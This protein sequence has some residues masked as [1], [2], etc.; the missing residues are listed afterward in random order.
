[1]ALRFIRIIFYSLLV[2]LF[3]LLPY[4]GWGQISSLPVP[5]NKYGH[6][7]EKIDIKTAPH[8]LSRT[9]SANKSFRTGKLIYHGG[10][11]LKSNSKKFGG[12]SGLSIS[13]DGRQ[14]LAVSD[15]SHWLKLSLDYNAQGQLSGAHKGAIL[16][17]LG[18][19]NISRFSQGD[20]ESVEQTGS[21]LLVSFEGHPRIEH[22][23]IQPDGIILHQGRLSDFN[24]LKKLRNNKSLESVARINSSTVITLAEQN[25]DHKKSDTPGYIIQNNQQTPFFVK[26][27]KK[28]SITDV[29]YHQGSLYFLERYFHKRS[30]LYARLSSFPLDKEI[31][32][33]PNDPLSFKTIKPKKLASF[34]LLHKLDNFEGISVRT[35]QSGRTFIYIISDDN[36]RD[37]QKTLLLMFEL[38]A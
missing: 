38:G 16:T 29:T 31:N 1:M 35:D 27:T 23:Q 28:F 26:K 11:E 21:E 3:L 15:R 14:L 20:S 22:Y 12:Y 30:G 4:Q 7:W 10:L 19:Q 32:Q 17:L 13:E 37:R 9:V 18:D 5:S 33:G 34:G 6:Q 8:Q 25:P 36:F 2:S 24:H